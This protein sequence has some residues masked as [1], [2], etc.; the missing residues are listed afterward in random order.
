MTAKPAA[1]MAKVCQLAPTT[2][3]IWARKIRI[4]SE[5]TKPLITERETNFT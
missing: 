1:T 2:W 5:L 3:G 4:A